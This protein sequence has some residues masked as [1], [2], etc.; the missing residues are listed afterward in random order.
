MNPPPSARSE[1]GDTSLHEQMSSNHRGDWITVEDKDAFD[2]CT[3]EHAVLRELNK[4]V[5]SSSPS[6]ND[7]YFTYYKKPGDS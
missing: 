2:T 6:E 7:D 1:F 3:P 5:T 4:N